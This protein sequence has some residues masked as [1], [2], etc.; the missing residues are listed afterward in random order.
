MARRPSGSRKSSRRAAVAHESLTVH[1][2]GCYEPFIFNSGLEGEEL[3]CP[4]CEH[5]CD[6]PD[7][8]QLSRVFDVQAAEKKGFRICLATLGVSLTSFAS[9]VGVSDSAYYLQNPDSQDMLFY[10]PM[11]LFIISSFALVVL[12]WKYE[13]NRWDIYF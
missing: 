4:V 11:G 9:W 10:G 8:G 12:A 6:R 13:K 5:M 7:D 3:V 2:S 1:C